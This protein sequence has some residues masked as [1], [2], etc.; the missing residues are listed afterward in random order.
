MNDFKLLREAALWETDKRASFIWRE[1]CTSKDII[2]I[3]DQH[4]GIGMD[5]H[6][7]EAYIWEIIPG[8]RR[9]GNWPC[10]FGLIVF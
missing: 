10:P 5:A 2:F 6:E 3:F 8:T 9:M 7:R 1:M 4:R